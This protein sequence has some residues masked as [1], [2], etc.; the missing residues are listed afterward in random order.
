MMRGGILLAEETPEMLIARCNTT[1]LEEAFLSLSY[2][3][4]TS[5]N[6]TVLILLSIIF[7]KIIIRNQLNEPIKIAIF[8]LRF[9][10]IGRRFV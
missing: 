2:K 5:S 10:C 4:E 8:V 3:Q 6:T 9:I 1:T 7:I